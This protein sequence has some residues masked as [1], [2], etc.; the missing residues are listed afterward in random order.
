MEIKTKTR[1]QGILTIM[2]ILAWLA[3]IGFMIKAGVILISYGVSCVNPEAARNLYMGLNL[4]NLSQFSFWHY[5]LSVFLMVAI[6]FAKA[7]AFFLAIRILMNVNMANPFK[8]EVAR[9]IQRIGYV[10][11]I[12]WFIA[13]AANAHTDWLLKTTGELYGD[14][15]ETEIIFMAGLVFIISQVFKRG[16]E[17]QSENDLTV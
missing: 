11:L 3:F 2:H 16:V 14:W 17:I 9:I 10:L 5:T 1:T 8:I 4:Y 6:L 12:T 7:F 13:V 15:V